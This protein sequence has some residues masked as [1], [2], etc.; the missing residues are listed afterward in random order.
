MSVLAAVVLV[1]IFALLTL[2]KGLTSQTK[3]VVVRQKTKDIAKE[4][5]SILADVKACT[6]AMNNNFSVIVSIDGS[7]APIGAPYQVNS[8]SPHQADVFIETIDVGIYSDTN[9]VAGQNVANS[10]G[11]ADRFVVHSLSQLRDTN[12]ATFSRNYSLMIKFLSPQENNRQ[13][14]KEI[15]NIQEFTDPNDSTK[16][17][18]TSYETTGI[19]DSVKA[20]CRSFGGVFYDSTARCEFREDVGG[21]PTGDPYIRNGSYKETLFATVCNNLG[22]ANY[23]SATKTC[24]GIHISG[25]I[26]TSKLKLNMLDFSSNSNGRRLGFLNYSCSGTQ[27]AVGFK[28]DGSIDCK[29]I[30][31]PRPSVQ[32]AYSN[33]S[34]SENSG[35]IECKCNKDRADARPGRQNCGSIDW[36]NCSSSYSVDDGCGTGTNCSI[37]GV[38]FICNCSHRYVGQWCNE[39]HY[40]ICGRRCQG[41]RCYAV[42]GGW[43]SWSTC[44]ASCGGGTM[45]RYCNSPYPSCGGSSCV[46]ASSQACNTQACP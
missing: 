21:A 43:S 42:N 28:E 5:R 33:W 29:P 27:V 10:N 45:Y 15:I 26:E 30:V 6:Y 31:C 24:N 25:T 4:M 1:S 32:N 36:T 20:F 11:S 23:N 18:C 19:A 16:R 8:I 40:S 14:G 7:G 39:T 3:K 38:P 9:L 44:S 13:I 12:A 2:S 17:L 35:R 41:T 22:S 34:P 46:G 37:Q